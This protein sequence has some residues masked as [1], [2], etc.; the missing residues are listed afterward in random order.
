MDKL[1]KQ[2]ENILNVA[3]K[4]NDSL[5]VATDSEIAESL[6]DLIGQLGAL[7]EEHLLLE[8]DFLY[9]ALKRRPQE[10]IRN[11]ASQFS[12]ELGGIKKAFSEYS[13]KWTSSENIV[14]SHSY[15][16]SESKAL[17]DALKKR[18]AK[19]NNELFPLIGT[20]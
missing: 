18:I 4:I 8:D 16:V 9:P 14:Q 1:R 6:L 7:L 17:M 13:G 2:H 10:A 12:I 15:F 11:I 5:E 20:V 19:E 3:G